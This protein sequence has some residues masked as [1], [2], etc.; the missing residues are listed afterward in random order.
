MISATPRVAP[1]K[2][3]FRPALVSLSIAG[4]LPEKTMATAFWEKYKD[5]KWQKRR[6]EIMDLAGFR[7]QSC[8]DEKTTLNIHHKFYR[9]GA[10]PWD[11]ADDE[12]ECLCAPCHESSHSAKDFLNEVLRSSTL[13]VSDVTALIAGFLDAN[14]AIDPFIADR[15]A[16]N[17]AVYYMVGLAAASVQRE[18]IA[19]KIPAPAM[20]VIDKYQREPLSPAIRRIF[21]HREEDDGQG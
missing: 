10:N 4:V 20:D 19:T 6:L 21:K 18:M 11:Y 2:A 12:L 1:E 8:G 7:C 16:E 9:K 17:N 13:P 15:A 14:V 5:P 3:D